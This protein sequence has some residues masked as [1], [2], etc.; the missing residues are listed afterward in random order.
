VQDAE[1]NVPLPRANVAGAQ[2]DY[3]VARINL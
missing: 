1:V 2:R 3:H